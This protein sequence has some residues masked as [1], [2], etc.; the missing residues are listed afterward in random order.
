MTKDIVKKI[1]DPE[2]SGLAVI[3]WEGWRPTWDRNFDSK[4]IY[5]SRSVDIVQEKYPEWSM[6]EQIQEAKKEFERSARIFMESSIKLAR[7]LRPKGLWG[8]YGFPDCFGSS[9]T[10]YRCSNEVS[11]WMSITYVIVLAQNF[12]TIF[13]IA[14]ILL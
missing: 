3:D 4:R 11:E 6:E 14:L 10:N 13:G 2:Y 12:L 5:Q 9:E 1:P 7:D 8:F